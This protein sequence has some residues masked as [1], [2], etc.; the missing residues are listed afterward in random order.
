MHPLKKCSLNTIEIC[1]ICEQNHDTNSF[2]SLPKFKES[3]QGVDEEGENVCFT[4][5]KKPWHPQWPT[6]INQGSSHFFNTY[7]NTLQF[8]SQQM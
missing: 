2:P 3:Y 4:T 1:G 6:G 8:P 7:W 5:P